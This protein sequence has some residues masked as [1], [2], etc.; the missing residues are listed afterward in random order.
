MH[1][2]PHSLNVNNHNPERAVAREH[3]FDL[4]DKLVNLKSVPE[5]N[6]A[7]IEAVIQELEQAQLAHKATYGLFGNNPNDDSTL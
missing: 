1:D 3:Y 2:S 6:L 7:A 4:R 5:P